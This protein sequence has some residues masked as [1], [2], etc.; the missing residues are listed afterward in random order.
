M[1]VPSAPTSV[2]V[3][4]AEADPPARHRVALR[5]GEELDGQLARPRHREDAGRRASVVDQI[6]VG[7][8]GDHPERLAL[9]Q[10]HHLLEERRLDDGARRVV[11]E[12]DDQALRLA[13]RAREGRF[14]LLERIEPGARRDRDR[15]AAGDDHAVAVDRVAGIGRQH[16]VARADD[17]QQE[18][19]EPL[20]GAQRDDRLRLRIER[21]P[22]T[23][24]VPVA[25]RLAHLGHPAR[26]HVALVAGALRLGD[27]PLDGGLRA[28]PVGVAEAEVEDVVPFGAQARLQLVD[29]R[30]DVRGK[31]GQARELVR[32][33]IGGA[34]HDKSGETLLDRRRDG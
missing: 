10:R 16:A 26:R 3:A 18:V 21:L 8:I 12:V 24:L 19:R 25:D 14:D 34:S 32:R 1:I 11:R 9:G 28:R 27:Q 31:R 30:Q 4:D 20:L 7:E 2:A 13:R 15:L 33:L 23:A 29:G 22:V 17:G 6:G 5:H